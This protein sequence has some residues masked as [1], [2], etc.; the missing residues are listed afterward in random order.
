M[1]EGVVEGVVDELGRDAEP[2]SRLAVVLQRGVEA[3]VLLVAADVG[4][5][6]DSA[7]A[8]EHARAPGVD[9]VQVLALQGV[10]VLGV[11]ET[12]ADAEVLRRLEV[13]GRA[14]HGGELRPQ[15]GDH[16]VGAGAAFLEGLQRDEHP[17]GVGA[18]SARAGA[19]G[20]SDQ[21]GDGGIGLDDADDLLQ[22]RAHG[23]E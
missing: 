3:L 21:R 10:L 20:E 23:L 13:E 1:A 8:A 19:A 9:L 17:A 5:Q 7:Q 6:P 11:A 4:Q 15:T 12:R 22:A 14:G 2:R 16:L 18:R